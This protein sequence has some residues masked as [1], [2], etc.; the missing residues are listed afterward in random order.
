MDQS[1]YAQ[2]REISTA[3][4]TTLLL[5]RGIRAIAMTGPKP[6]FP[7][8]PRIAGPAFTLQ[9]LPFREDLYDPAKAGDPASSQRRAIE[10]APAGSV[11]VI[12]TGPNT[13]AGCL[14]DIL[15]A[16]LQQ[17]GLAGVVTDGALRDAAAIA[18]LA[19]PVFAGGAA[20]PSSHAAFS[21]GGL[22]IPVAC[23]GITVVPGDV[24]VAD[25]DGAV[26]IPAQLAPEIAEAGVEQERLESFIAE[27]VQ[28]G[29]AIP[30]LYPPDAETLKAYKAWCQTQDGDQDGDAENA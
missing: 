21:D 24:V 1:L 16:R 6:L 18:P 15:V 17:R 3:T 10:E 8:Q 30:G 5:K 7:D 28:R 14:G 27:E 19:F 9:F 22:Q 12:A 26:V 29:H 11:L 2:L 20:A 13:A 23:G 25:G 4:I